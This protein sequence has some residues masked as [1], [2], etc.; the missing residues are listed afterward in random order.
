MTPNSAC[1]ACGTPLTGGFCPRCLL[2]A[3][4]SP[5]S[6]D[7]SRDIPDAS[8][9]A[10]LGDYEL[11]EEVGRGGMG[12]V[13]RARQASLDRVV[14]IK[15]LPFGGL[16]GKDAALRL[17]A[18]AVA[19]G[20][21]RH[22]NI[23]AIH[24]VGLQDGQHF[25]AMDYVAGSSLARVLRDGPI[26]ARRAA[27][28]VRQVALAVAHAHEH[29]IIHRD[30][31]PSNILLDAAEDQPRVTDFGLAKNL[32]SDTQ[33]T[34][35]GQ[36][37]GSP[38]YIPPEQ[39]RGSRLQECPSSDP[40]VAAGQYVKPAEPRG[41][42]SFASD[43]Y[44]LGA[45]LYHAV[46][47]R[48]PFMG[49]DIAAVLH[50][51]VQD[52]PVPPRRL[53]PSVP[54][55]LETICLKCLEKQSTRRYATA[56]ELAEELARFLDDEPIH[57]RPA[58]QPERVWRWCRKNATVAT[59]AA[60]TLLLLLTVAIGGPL[61]A[62]RINGQ[63]RQA[64]LR[65][66]TADMNVVHQAYED[67][68]LP[69]ARRLLR[70]YVPPPGGR[71]LRGVE[72]RFLANLCRDQSLLTLNVPGDV[73]CLAFSSDKTTL[74][75]GA[76]TNV[77]LLDAKDYRQKGQLSHAGHV[78]T[79]A[80]CA[81]IPDIIATGGTDDPHIRLWELSSRKVLAELASVGPQINALAF[82]PQGDLLA[83]ASET[84][85][86]E[87]WD[88][89]AYTNLWRRQLPHPSRTVLFS[90]D[91][92]TLI[93]GG[94]QE[95]GNALFW[96]AHTGIRLPGIPPAHGGWVVGAV[97]SPN[98]RTLATRGYD[99]TVILWDFPTRSRLHTFTVDAGTL[100]FSP[101]GR[102]FAVG[103]SDSLLR[104]W[105]LNE[106]ERPPVIRRGH[107]ANISAMTFAPDGETI[108]TGG[109]DKTV[110]IWDLQTPADEN[111]LMKAE[112]WITTVAISADDRLLLAADYHQ[113]RAALFN[114]SSR[115]WITNFGGHSAAV[116]GV[117]FSPD[118][119]WC[120]TASEDKTVRLWNLASLSVA[121]IFT[122]DFESTMPTFSPDG[123][124]LAVAGWMPSG[125]QRTTTLAFWDVNSGLKLERLKEAGRQATTARF[126]HTGQQ[127]AV[128]YFDGSVK[129]WDWAEQRLLYA[130]NGEGYEVWALAFSRDDSLLAS[131]GLITIHDLQRH[132]ASRLEGYGC[133]S[134]V[135]SRDGKSLISVSEDGLLFWNVA[136]RSLALKYNAHSAPISGLAVNSDDTLLATS[137]ADGTVRLWTAPSFDRIA[138][139]RNQ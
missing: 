36:T 109:P 52:E 11:L 91:G 79:V 88:C 30:L 93:S 68:K 34:L 65:A 81:A 5:G 92:Q 82:S 123:R 127:L 114:L 29:G 6:D 108:F 119:R 87:V 105:N 55:D 95:G 80:A 33:L 46:T 44:S 49:D 14:A 3:G 32:R 25:I 18:E 125:P 73:G 22:P 70:S 23:V 26:S 43:V 35:T 107:G 122:N 48:P 84:G 128:G 7:V 106:P 124:V 75:V 27:T 53:N 129:V 138:R 112:H 121:R 9:L 135:F 136:T 86:I 90:S 37:L 134:L 117:A 57:V 94:S 72:W 76:G 1:A 78:S 64:E 102:T 130:F 28:L 45:I 40:E 4:I 60:A 62:F 116:Q 15:L 115:Q 120:A 12:V 111:L 131:S 20:S 118:G 42:V 96:G 38:N 67:G 137:S 41:K 50:Q 139:S 110:R 39:I 69:R 101:D 103:G 113:N 85:G 2:E 98:G 10:R 132:E 31:K 47:G 59:L 104:I 56:R 16:G 54:I 21:L 126:S 24:E 97:F 77:W 63:R 89:H 133:A 100:A 66:Y 8:G 71:D 51:V 19:A 61:A 83:W 58:T 17:R 13:Y 99:G 74:L